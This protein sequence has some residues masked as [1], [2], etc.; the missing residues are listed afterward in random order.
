[1]KLK[2]KNGR[3]FIKFL[4]KIWKIF[5]NGGFM[6]I[7]TW[8]DPYD[9]GFTPTKA[10][11]I[12]LNTG[13]T[14]LVGC[15]GA[16]KTTLLRNISEECRKQNI[17]C[18]FYDNLNDGGKSSFAEMFYGNDLQEAAYL[19]SASEGECIKANLGRKSKL[20]KEFIEKG[21]VNDHF[22]R[23]SKLLDGG[24]DEV[25]ESNDRV[26]LFDAVDSGL[27]VDS[28]VEIKSLFDLI[29]DDFKDSGKNIY[30]VI[31]A[32]EYELAR[33][34][35]CF[36]V[37]KGEYIRFKDYEEYRSFIIRSRKKKD[38]R[39][40][41]QIVW[42]EKQKQKEIKK[43]LEIKE[44]Q[45]EAMEKLRIKKEKGEYVDW[46]EEDRIKNMVKDYLR[47]TAR[48]ITENDVADIT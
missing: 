29:L 43:Y 37:N 17:P 34:S 10:K 41:K 48:F 9:A 8:R 25:I 6:K 44:K 47:N 31:A 33:N 19:M 26:F 21:I 39:I 36:D 2:W 46:F 24:K 15:N 45:E 14:V 40:E 28:V 16:G 13:L 11:E 18:L 22:Y 5:K 32:N 3:S 42:R 35:E 20:F 27:S 38:K 12:E 23:F 7:N 1:M 4:K 30:I